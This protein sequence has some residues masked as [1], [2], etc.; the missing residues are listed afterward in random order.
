[1]K[2]ARPWGL[3]IDG[4]VSRT[5][6]ARLPGLHEHLGPVKSGSYR[7]ASRAANALRAGRPA[8]EY[9]ELNDCELVL[10]LSSD[11]HLT[12]VIAEL[13]EAPLDWLHKTLVL[14]HATYDSRLL[15]PFACRGAMTATLAPAGES[16]PKELLAEGDRR[17]FSLLRRLTSPAFRLS[18]VSTEGKALAAA[19]LSLSTA[20]FQPVIAAAVDSLRQSGL[21]QPDATR[22]ALSGFVETL[23]LY[24]RAGARSQA[25]HYDAPAVTRQLAVLREHH[26]PHSTLR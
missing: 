9:H 6:W 5:V 18:L 17:A 1:M 26:S 12:K 22:L 20:L 11:V 8:R 10:V 2:S 19:G 3:V 16:S 21:P 23:R 13:T 25:A 7:L 15:Q 24:Q 14:W 4:P